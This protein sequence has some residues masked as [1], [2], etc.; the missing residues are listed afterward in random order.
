MLAYQLFLDFSKNSY[1]VDMYKVVILGDASVGKTSLILSY[2]GKGVAKRPTVGIEIHNIQTQDDK[3]IVIWDLSG[4]GKFRTVLEPY[5]KGANLYIL[6]FDLTRKKTLDSLVEWAKIINEISGEAK[7]IIVGNKKDL[8][9]RIPNDEVQRVLNQLKLNIIK[10]VETS[11]LTGENI[12]E[13]I[14]DIIHVIK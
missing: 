2:M 12:R 6:V 10:Y 5:L 8:D 1:G 11:A 4:Q 3:N 13:L 7:V 9:N 14:N